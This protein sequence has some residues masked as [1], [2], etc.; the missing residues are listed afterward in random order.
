MNVI[1]DILNWVRTAKPEWEEKG[2]KG[3]K[4]QKDSILVE[5]LIF[6]EL[7][8]LKQARLDNDMI[9]YR[10]AL[11]DLIWVVTNAY[12]AIGMSA[13]EI[14][15]DLTQI[16]NSNWSKF[17][18]TEK[19]AIKTC[20]LYSIGRHPD[21]K[22]EFISAVYLEINGKFVIFRKSDHKILKSYKY[23]RVNLS[24]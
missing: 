24:K 18:D 16:S 6:E 12:A 7:Q 21:K 5:D 14:Q 15:D 17:C 11:G 23:K 10:D 19:D 22:D 2:T 1:K 4:V 3:F 13:D 20:S 9:E 8:E